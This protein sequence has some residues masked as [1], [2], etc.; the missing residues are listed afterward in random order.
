MWVVSFKMYNVTYCILWQGFISNPN[1]MCIFWVH[2]FTAELKI[3]V[4]FIQHNALFVYTCVFIRQTQNSQSGKTVLIIMA[5]YGYARVSTIDQSLT[6]QIQILRA[7]GGEIIHAE[8]ASGSRRSGISELSCYRTGYT[9]RVARVARSI[10]RLQN[11]VYART[12]RA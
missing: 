6:L 2:V 3:W 7:A 8:K 5:L 12:S 11:T 10:K 1:V 4:V 9:L